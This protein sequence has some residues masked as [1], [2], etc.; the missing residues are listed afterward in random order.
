M[1]D[2]PAGP[3]DRRSVSGSRIVPLACV[4]FI[5]GCAAV[6]RVAAIAPAYTGTS[7][8]ALHVLLSMAMIAAWRWGGVA[9][10]QLILLTGIAARLIL[11]AAPMLSSNDAERYLWDGAVALAGF[12]PYSVPPAD[13]LV[14]TLRA[15]WATPPEH[16]AYA[17]LYPP[18]ALGLFAL[19]ALAGPV[20]G[21]W[22]WK[23]IASLAG[24]ALVL[25]AQR[26]LRR[27][28]MER[29]LA[30]VAL[31]PLLVLET[32]VGAHIDVMVALLIT[33]ALLA[34]VTRRWGMAG[35]LLGLG[36]CVKLLP[37]AALVALAVA[38]GRRRGAWM[39]V[40][41]MGTV[42]VVYGAALTIGWRPIGSLP[43]FFE[44]W[45]NGSPLFTLLEWLLPNP[46]LLAVIAVLA[47]GAGV[48]VLV[49]A[50]A[51]PVIAIQ[52]ALAIPLV[53]SPV[54]FPWYL[55]ALVPVVA[56]APSATLLIW[57]TT[58]PLIYEVRDRFVSAGIWMPAIWPLI[59]IGAGWAVG[60]TID[61]VRARSR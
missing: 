16:A 48:T 54:A 38:A 27:Y 57:L 11:I 49:L 37:G 41:A 35:V 3:G 53:L 18:A 23:L 46:V 42:V 56:V 43:V 21:I 25:V 19:S 4:A 26:L 5:M 8:I 10:L 51:R 31:S 55:C 34:V 60:L 45:R 61:A 39:T 47:I 29:H 58:S 13:P 36:I 1:I 33:A 28:G 12:D 6:Y 52:L 32:G 40:A 22:L 20:W 50:R 17:T 15:I 9:Q 14:A 44:K 7:Y 59:V 30:L 24:I 2:E